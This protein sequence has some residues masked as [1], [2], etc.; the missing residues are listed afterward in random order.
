VRSLPG[1]GIRGQKKIVGKFGQR[2]LQRFLDLGS[3]G[4]VP[5]NFDAL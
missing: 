5:R 4:V 2:R 1:E 3:D